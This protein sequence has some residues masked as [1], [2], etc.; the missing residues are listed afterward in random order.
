MTSPSDLDA[1]VPV[2]LTSPLIERGSG[3]VVWDTEGHRYVDLSA[4]PGV[5]SVGHCHPR[6]V[7]AVRRQAGTLMQSPGHS[8]TPLMLSLARRLTALTDGRLPTVFYTN[9]GADAADGAVKFA[10]RHARHTGNGG[11]TLL[12]I[13]GG[14]HGRTA[15]P[16]AL[17]GISNRKRGFGPYGTW[18]GLVHLPAPNCYR[19]PFGMT[20][21]SC[22]LRC[23]SALE[24]MLTTAVP[25]EPVALIAEAVQGVGGVLIPPP[26]YWP[27]IQRTC[28]EHG[29]TLIVDE[30]FTGFG[31][32]GRAFAYQHWSVRPD[33][34]TFAK[35][36]GGGIPLG[37]VLAAAKIADTVAAGDHYTTFG[38]NN[39]VGLAAAHAVLDVLADEDLSARANRL[40]ERMRQ[41]L[42]ALAER[43]PSVGDVR[44]IGLF[45]GVELV[46]DRHAKTP[47]PRLAKQ[48]QARLLADGFL[49]SI[50]GVNHNVIRLTPPLVITDEQVDDAVAA[51]D[52][53]LGAVEGGA[54]HEE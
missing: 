45:L 35:A 46:T 30:V 21:P 16:L 4:G 10:Y 52:A 47:A 48:A 49:V 23:A 22:E 36:V 12:A 25:S 51:I 6:V 28:H 7:D 17:T 14:F 3:S 26:E 18:P 13:E 29:I 32:T 33:M 43:H 27:A 24:R 42:E 50:A 44:G 19:C 31:R 1:L 5:L 37:G 2:P 20:Y 54:G 9:S 38:G 39:Q 15:L 41:D 8:Y 40:G 34:V 11:T 53:A